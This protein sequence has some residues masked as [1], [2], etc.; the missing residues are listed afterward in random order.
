LED[1]R[2][3]LEI[4]ARMRLIELAVQRSLLTGMQLDRVGAA[5]ASVDSLYLGA[6]RARG[7]VAPSVRAV[8]PE[9]GIVGGLGLDSRPGL[10]RNILVFDF[11]SLYPSIIRTFNVDPLTHVPS[12]EGD[13]IRTPGGAAFRRTEPGILPELVARLAEERARARVAGDPIAAQ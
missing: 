12:G 3:V 13:V 10:Y 4:L 9:G 11:K 1:A 2:L 8:E 5:I 6:L 7:R